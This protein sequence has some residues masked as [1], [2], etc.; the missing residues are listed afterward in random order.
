MKVR[1]ETRKWWDE[2]SSTSVTAIQP[3]NA[4]AACPDGKPP[5]SGVPRPVTALIAMT[6]MI[7]TA[8]AMSVSSSWTFAS[9]SRNLELRSATAPEKTRYPTARA[10]S[11]AMSTAPAAMS[12]AS[13]AI[14]SNDVEATSTAASIAVFTSSATRTNV[15]ASSSTISSRRSTPNASAAIST[16]AAIVKW[17]QRFRCV[18]SAWMTPSVA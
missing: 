7:V 9:R 2:S 6:R 11:A 17:I 18:R 14:G 8:S 12:F 15:M 13:F 10:L 1:V 3:A 16:P 5:R 4:T